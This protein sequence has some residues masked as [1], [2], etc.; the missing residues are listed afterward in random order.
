MDA[1]E[2][3]AYVAEKWPQ[4]LHSPLA[5]AVQDFSS[6]DQADRA[7][8]FAKLQASATEAERKTILRDA[9]EHAEA[10]LN[11]CDGWS[12]ET[13]GHNVESAFGGEL[14][15]DACD[16]ISRQALARRAAGNT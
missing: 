6:A 14:D 1:D 11:T 4:A 15:A 12:V 16:E 2:V 8:G 13:L 10:C 3:R 9:M 7:M 5:R